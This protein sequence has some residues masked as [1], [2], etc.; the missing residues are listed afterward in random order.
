M[1]LG[2]DHWTVECSSQPI[3]AWVCEDHYKNIA[4]KLHYLCLFPRSLPA[5]WI[6]KD[7][8]ICVRLT[9]GGA[10]LHTHRA[11]RPQWRERSLCGT[12]L[13]VCGEYVTPV[14]QSE[15]FFFS[16]LI[17]C[18]VLVNTGP[19]LHSLCTLNNCCS[20]ANFSWC[21]QTA[22]DK[23][24]ILLRCRQWTASFPVHSS[25]PH[26]LPLLTQKKKK[27]TQ[28]CMKVALK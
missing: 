10:E 22:T 21:L 23:S 11:E 26:F 12:F 9:E 28:V 1:F 24:C 8:Q 25:H 4:T 5:S 7:L 2:V 3:T 27:K 20:L 18:F 19:S 14:N 13:Q 15:F 16:F 17:H 6:Y